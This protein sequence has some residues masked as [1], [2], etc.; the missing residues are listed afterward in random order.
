[1][2]EVAS[3][4]QRSRSTPHGDVAQRSYMLFSK[5]QSEDGLLRELFL[6]LKESAGG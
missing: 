2:K 5:Y 6:G 3:R 4:D 1:M